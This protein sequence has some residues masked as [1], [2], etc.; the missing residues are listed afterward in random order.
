MGSIDKHN[1]R[2]ATASF[3]VVLAGL[4]PVKPA[5]FGLGVGQ[6]MAHGGSG[7]PVAA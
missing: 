3:A 5:R 7:Q 4:I 2:T 1:F 6:R